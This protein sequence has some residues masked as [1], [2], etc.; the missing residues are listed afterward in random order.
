MCKTQ[1]GHIIHTILVRPKPAHKR[2]ACWLL[3]LGQKR[4]AVEGHPTMFRG[5]CTLKYGIRHPREE[6]ILHQSVGIS[7]K[8]MRLLL[9]Y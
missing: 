2:L 6:R 8:H 3:A 1:L 9:T 4:L 5:Q 7:G